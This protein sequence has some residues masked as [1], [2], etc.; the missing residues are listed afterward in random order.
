MDGALY[1]KHAGGA[2][3]KGGAHG[4]GEGLG[5]L[6]PLPAKYQLSA[7]GKLQGFGDAK[8]N[9][10]KNWGHMLIDG[11]WVWMDNYSFV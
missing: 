10:P 11:K 7:L 3:G 8:G 1:G 4:R 2:Q 6:G 5:R 9:F